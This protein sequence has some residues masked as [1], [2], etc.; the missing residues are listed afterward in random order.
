[1]PK[2]PK[3]SGF[4]GLLLDQQGAD[5]GQFESEGDPLTQN[6]MAGAGLDPNLFT[7]SQ[8]RGVQRR[9]MG[10]Q[11][12]M[13][14]AGDPYMANPTSSPVDL[15][16][17]EHALTGGG[18]S[19]SMAQNP[20]NLVAGGGGEQPHLPPT[21]ARWAPSMM[22][23]DA[24]QTMTASSAVPPLQE[25]PGHML[26][27]GRMAEMDAIQAPQVPGTPQLMPQATDVAHPQAA[28]TASMPTTNTFFDPKAFT[29]LGVRRSRM[30]A[31]RG[32]RQAAEGLSPDERFPSDEE[33]SLKREWE[34]MNQTAPIPERPGQPQT[35]SSA[36]SWANLV[37][38]QTATTTG[39][40]A[41]YGTA[42]QVYRNP[43]FQRMFGTA[44]GNIARDRADE[45]AMRGK[46]FAQQQMMGE[47]QIQ[48][49][50]LDNYMKS[51]N[52]KREQDYFSP[53]GGTATGG[54][55][56]PTSVQPW[57]IEQQREK[58]SAEQHATEAK[59]NRMKILGESFNPISG[60]MDY[61]GKPRPG[62]EEFYEGMGVKMP[63]TQTASTTEVA[64]TA[65]HAE[66]P[67]LTFARN[68][69]GPAVET[70]GVA[71]ALTS[72]GPWYSK[73]VKAGLSVAGGE[74]LKNLLQ[75]PEADLVNPRAAKYGNYLGYILGGGSVGGLR[76]KL[77]GGEAA[78][79]AQDAE[80]VAKIPG[81][82]TA[83]KV[84]Q[85]A[86]DYGKRFVNMFKKEPKGS[87]VPR[88]VTPQ[89]GSAD[90]PQPAPKQPG[91]EYEQPKPYG[92]EYGPTPT[93]TAAPVTPSQMRP[94]GVPTMITKQMEAKLRAQ[95]WTT[96]QINTMTP[97]QAR[98]NL[99]LVP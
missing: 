30:A 10:Q 77:L 29:A 44:W 6:A 78:G 18:D 40:G 86:E 25:A 76:N 24:G 14:D 87:T 92:W 99:K 71:R 28:A 26:H 93:S 88:P 42:P 80:L 84:K 74:A 64:P 5:M 13:F 81:G 89:P 57:L 4:G 59:L 36:S 23:P 96:K 33:E 54:G 11:P 69:A 47:K 68:A 43:S 63:Q 98:Q 61:Q 49:L 7:P 32:G 1:M 31:E 94:K 83:M 20:L 35:G 95:G 70:H 2:K 79:A 90:Y 19:V 62:A 46:N 58:A 72:R 17:L 75:D 8:Q 82:A 73:A 16:L 22:N 65:A 53:G 97:Q 37:R 91:W 48:Q 15:R 38:P 66:A 9:V 50:A 51:M 56:P 45:V 60:P 21:Q 52:I 34:M 3:K 55:V 85:G 12:P 27:S 39:V 67:W 41:D